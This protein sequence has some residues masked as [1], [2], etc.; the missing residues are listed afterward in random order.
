MLDPRFELSGDHFL[1][2]IQLPENT[3][4]GLVAIERDPR[5]LENKPDCY[6]AVVEKVGPDCTFVK[7]GDKIVLE[8]WEYEQFDVDESRLVAREIDGLIFQDEKPAPNTFALQVLNRHLQK[9]REKLIIPEAVF[10]D[11]ERWF[12]GK[13]SSSS[14]SEVEVG[15]FVWV[16]KMDS[17]QFNLGEFTVVVRV[18]EDEVFLKGVL[19]SEEEAIC[20]K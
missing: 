4:G 7:P 16:S 6:V 1:G 3:S 14:Y 19:V 18:S 9:Y 8:R 20:Q 15:N 12:F 17:G 11:P 10:A 5:R 13:V 2:N